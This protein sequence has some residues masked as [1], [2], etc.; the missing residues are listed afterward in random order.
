MKIKIITLISLIISISMISLAY[1]IT[2]YNEEV[3]M[4]YWNT[5]GDDNSYYISSSEAD[6]SV[7]RG[8]SPASI[9]MFWTPY[10]YDATNNTFEKYYWISNTRPVKVVWE[11]YDPTMHRIA[12]IK[13]D[14]TIVRE[15]NFNGYRYLFGDEV[16][17]VIP[18]LFLPERYGTWVGRCYWIFEDGSK[19]NEGPII[20]DSGR[21]YMIA[22]DVVK[23]SA[24][25]LIFNAPI[26]IFGYKTV[27][28]FWWLSPIWIFLILFLILIIYTKSVV[29]A[30]RVFKKAAEATREAR[31]EYRR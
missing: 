3:R 8:Y 10:F 21:S 5:W 24:I 28:L 26:Y 23:G 19:G 18:A 2:T 30:V 1:P 22:F 6:I 17:F 20:D 16:S 25:D 14:P 12:V 9:F 15:G 13:K 11:F 29:G 4:V 7:V 31:H 27:S